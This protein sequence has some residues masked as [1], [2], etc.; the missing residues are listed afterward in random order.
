[1]GYGT[2]ASNT[3]DGGAC[4]TAYIELFEA[5]ADGRY[6]ES[7]RQGPYCGTIAPPDIISVEQVCMAKF[8]LNYFTNN[9]RLNTTHLPNVCPMLVHRLRHWP[10]IGQTLGRCVVFAWILGIYS[11]IIL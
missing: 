11:Y 5:T 2:G 1:M 6:I 9:I 4:D 10:N 8:K 7:T 3:A